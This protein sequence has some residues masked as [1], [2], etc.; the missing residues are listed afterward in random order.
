MNKPFNSLSLIESAK[1]TQ[2]NIYLSQVDEN[3]PSTIDNQ[4]IE[5]IDKKE[6]SSVIKES[7]YP[8][9]LE[10]QRRNDKL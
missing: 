2:S 5:L 9:E 1:S 3:Q 7:M 4:N 6:E 8:S 10:S